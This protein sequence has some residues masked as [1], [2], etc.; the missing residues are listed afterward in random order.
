MPSCSWGRFLREKNG[1]CA[2]KICTG[3]DFSDIY[4]KAALSKSLAVQRGATQ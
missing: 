3:G 4:A 1:F 2:L